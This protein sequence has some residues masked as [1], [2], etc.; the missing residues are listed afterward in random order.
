M[1]LERIVELST[2][3]TI[4]FA[5]ITHLNRACSPPWYDRLSFA[6]VA[7]GACWTAF[8]PLGMPL[9]L[10]G[11]AC[12]LVRHFAIERRDPQRPRQHP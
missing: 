8:D 11:L 1:M 2:F 12:V 4:L 5:A 3:G 9:L 10:L 7:A 6:G